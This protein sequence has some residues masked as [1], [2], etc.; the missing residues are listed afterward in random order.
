MFKWDGDRVALPGLPARV[1]RAKALTGGPAE[2]QQQGDQLTVRVPPASQQEMD[3]IIQ[4][5]LDQSAM[6]LRP[7]SLPEANEGP[8]SR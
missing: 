5:D 1:R 8:G 4:L 6:N 3:T 7:V 2:F